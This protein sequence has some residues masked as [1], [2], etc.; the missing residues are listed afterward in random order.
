[1]KNQ[2]NREVPEGFRP[3][4]SSNNYHNDEYQTIPE[5]AKHNQIVFLDSLES[6]FSLFKIRDGMTLSFHHH[7]RNGDEVLNQTAEVV[8]KLNLRDMHFA[9][10]SIFP[11]NEILSELIDSGNISRV[12]TNYLNG[13]VAKTISGGHLKNLLVMETHGGRARS[14]E[15]GEL[16][17]DVA[18]LATPAVDKTGNGTGALGKNACGSLGYAIPD[19]KYAKKV[20]LVTDALVDHL[21]DPEF[22]S[23]YVDAV[24]VLPNIGERKGIV[25]GTTKITND[26]VGL[27]MA[28]D[29]ARLLSELG[30]IQPGFSMQTGAGGTTLA[31]AEYVK[32]LMVEKKI[33]GEFASGGI[34]GYYVKMLEQGL[35]KRLYDVQCFDLEAVESYRTNRNHFAISASEYGN[36]HFPKP[37]VN[38]LD[39]VILGA[40]EIDTDFNVNVTTDSNGWIIGG[41]GGHSDTANGAKLTVITTNLIKSRMPIIKKHVMTI[42]TPGEDVDI[43]VTERGIAINPRRTDLL[44][45]LKDS[46]LKIMGIADLLELSHR[47]TMEPMAF[48]HGQKIIGVVKYR[49][50]SIIDSLYQVKKSV[51]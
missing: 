10:S 27:K 29:T 16:A 2:I 6:A 34:T 50:G 7:L 31:V 35:F 36:P 37:I 23:E 15:T 1:M 42:T 5:K 24:V 8:K 33:V 9:P 46:K 25:S 38:S 21:D 49:D 48:K 18:F 19:L 11:N 32:R 14:V 39:F 28:R 4:V 26:P 22:S 13:P 41:S 45:K 12:T 40:T 17:I 47:I 30:M 20:V 3:F 51:N 44:E 43:L